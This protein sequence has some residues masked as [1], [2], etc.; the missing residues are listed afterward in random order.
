MRRVVSRALPDGSVR[1]VQ[2]Y[3]ISLEGL[4]DNVICRDDEDYDTMV[5]VI[6][7]CARRKNVIVIIYAV[8]SNHCH[9]AVLAVSQEEADNFAEEVKR[10]Y[11]MWLARKYGLRGALKGVDVQALLLDTDWYTR[12]AL[13]YV[14]RNALDNGC[15]VNEYPWS[16][17]KAMFTAGC[18]GRP[19]AG[20]GKNEMRAVMRTGDD[21]RG[22]TWRVDSEDHLIPGS[23]C[24][25][26]YL[27][28]VFE[29]DQTYFLKTIGGQNS[30]EMRY[31]LI[32]APRKRFPDSEFRKTV[33]EVCR[34]WF[35]TSLDQISFERKCRL[36]PYVSRTMRTTVPQ[37]ARVFALPRDQVSRILGR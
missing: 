15:N 21:L 10:V 17:F 14:P 24:D 23:F 5:K 1:Y 28:Q 33:E 9:A 3:H 19:V 8:V 16:G 2:P 26:E 4:E 31:R 13:A 6:C 11:S 18:H 30:A 25:H 22:V 29:N 27:E 7:V 34:H 35:Q 32:D 37:L 12:N 20:M 36:I